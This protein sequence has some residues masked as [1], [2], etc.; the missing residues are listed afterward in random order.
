MSITEHNENVEYV[1]VKVGQLNLLD[2]SGQLLKELPDYLQSKSTVVALYGAMVLNRVFDEQAIALQRTGRLGTFASA[3]GQEAPSVAAALAMQAGDVFIPSFR[4]QGGQLARGVTVEELLSYWGG[5]ERGSAYSKAVHDFPV[6]I[7]VGSQ[8]PQAAG[9]ALAFKLKSESHVAVVFGGDGSTSKGDFYEG[10]NMAGVWN[11]PVVFFI[12]NNQWAISTPR[13]KQTHAGTLSQKALAGGVSGVQVD[14]NDAL[15][16]YQCV[17]EALAKA[18]RGDGP[19][20]I[21]A[22]TYRMSD[23]TTADDANRYRDKEEVSAHLTDDPIHRLNLYLVEHCGW[24]EP[25]EKALRQSCSDDV[26]AGVANYLDT[27]NASP[28]EMFDSLFAAFPDSL[29]LQREAVATTDSSSAGN[30]Q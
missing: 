10:L 17:T 16:V 26:A 30:V 12:I 11:L 2:Q 4:E 21:E 15:A 27:K 5:D 20:L 9:V 1:K 3:L 23:H 8:Y 6:C 14:G 25:D 19:T 24:T 29:E 7:P 22:I 28:V 13:N 18:R